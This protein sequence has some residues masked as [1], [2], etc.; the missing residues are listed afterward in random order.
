MYSKWCMSKCVHI[1]ANHAAELCNPGD[2]ICLS[3][4]IDSRSICLAGSWSRFQK[5]RS[6]LARSHA[7]TLSCKQTDNTRM[8]KGPIRNRTVLTTKL[9]LTFSK[10]RF[11]FSAMASPFRFLTRF[12]SS[13]LQAYILPVA[14]TWQAQTWKTSNGENAVTWTTWLW[15][16]S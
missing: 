6:Q 4:L 13:F 12:F 7:L 14:R 16:A 5:T 3:R 10:M 1:F 9:L 2:H 15:S 11:S 8:L